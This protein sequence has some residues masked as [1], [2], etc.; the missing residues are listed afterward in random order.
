MP[1]VRS[2]EKLKSMSMCMTTDKE[3]EARMQ[4]DESK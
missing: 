1:K 2:M 3:R 4:G